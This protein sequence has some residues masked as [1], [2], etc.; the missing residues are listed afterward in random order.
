MIIELEIQ[1]DVEK[2]IVEDTAQ[3]VDEEDEDDEQ[4]ETSILEPFIP[5]YV[6]LN[7]SID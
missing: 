4:E 6:K 3:P 7:H 2:N 5:R 1:I